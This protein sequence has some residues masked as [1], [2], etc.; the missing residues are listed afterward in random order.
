MIKFTFFTI[1]FVSLNSLQY[2]N[3][4][5]FYL[6]FL[7]LIFTLVGIVADWIIVPRFHNYVSSLMGAV[8]MGGV[9]Y[10]LPIL[11]NIGEVSLMSAIFLALLLG[12]VE[13]TLHY[14]IVK[15]YLTK[16]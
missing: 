2:I 12:M 10:L 8:F 9:T 5:S 15:R 1:I 6:V 16:A 4:P 13:A 7:P 11:F 14:L 3:L